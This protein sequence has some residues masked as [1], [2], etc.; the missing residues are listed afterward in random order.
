MLHIFPGFREFVQDRDQI[1]AHDL[2]FGRKTLL[3]RLVL[4]GGKECFDSA[5]TVDQLRARFVDKYCSDCGFDSHFLHHGY[6]LSAKI[7][8]LA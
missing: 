1:A 3:S 5:F 7:K 6:T 2:E 4:R 8:L